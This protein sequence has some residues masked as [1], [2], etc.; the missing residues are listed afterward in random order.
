MTPV[1][2]QAS[3]AW[4]ATHWAPAAGSIQFWNNLGWR[5]KSAHE[6]KQPYIRTLSF[7]PYCSCFTICCC[8]TSQ[9]TNKW[10]FVQVKGNRC[11]PWNILAEVL[12]RYRLLV[13]FHFLSICSKGLMT[14]ILF[15][16][17]FLFSIFHFHCHSWWLRLCKKVWPA[18]SHCG[19]PASSLQPLPGCGVTRSM[20]RPGRG[21]NRYT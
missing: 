20:K 10:T 9:L 17:S 16:I 12:S 14:S 21:F 13:V 8:H 19:Q 4:D 2:V 6:M 5:R 1:M 15:S 7:C 3:A 11:H 18:E